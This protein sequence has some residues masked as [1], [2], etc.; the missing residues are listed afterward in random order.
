MGCITVIESECCSAPSQV[1]LGRDILYL[2]KTVPRR[3]GEGI[4]LELDSRF[5][6]DCSNVEAVL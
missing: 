3:V 5:D 4:P 1:F 6:V 2:L